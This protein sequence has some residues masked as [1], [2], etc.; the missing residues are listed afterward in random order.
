VSDYLP[1]GQGSR[2]ES[3]KSHDPNAIQNSIYGT[4]LGLI[5]GV[6]VSNLLRTG[7]NISEKYIDYLNIFSFITGSN[8]IIASATVFVAISFLS[9]IIS[10]NYQANTIMPL[11]VSVGICIG[12]AV[13]FSFGYSL[14]VG[15]LFSVFFVFVSMLVFNEKLIKGIR[16]L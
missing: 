2:N 10:E 12:T 6:A 13:S 7:S 5:L 15:L 3:N 14:I 11:H 4:I 9:Y 8:I 16:K 1:N